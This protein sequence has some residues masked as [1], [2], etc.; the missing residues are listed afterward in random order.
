MYSNRVKNCISAI[1]IISLV[2]YPFFFKL[3]FSKSNYEFFDIIRMVPTYAWVYLFILCSFLSVLVLLTE[4][5]T[6]THVIIA[7][8]LV[9]GLYVISQYP[10]EIH[11]DFFVHGRMTLQV[12]LRGGI[13]VLDGYPRWWP[14][15]FIFWAFSSNVMGLG[16][17]ETGIILTFVIMVT[18]STLLYLLA[19]EI[20]GQQWAGLAT[21]LYL[22]TCVYAF[23]SMGRDHFSPGSIAFTQYLLFLYILIRIEKVQKFKRTF[24][25]IGSIMILCIVLSHGFTSLYLF[26]T[27]FGI[28]AIQKIRGT[29]LGSSLS[30][31]FFALTSWFA[32]WLFN[33]G[34][35]F[36]EAILFLTPFLV[37]P[38]E[39]KM[40]RIA[41]P[42]L[43]EPLPITGIILRN[44]YIK[45]LMLTI[46]FIS[47]LVAFK[48]RKVKIVSVYSGVLLGILA[49]SAIALA[50]PAETIVIQ[51]P[52]MLIFGLLPTC[53]LA[54]R[55]FTKNA[56][57]AKMSSCI[58]IFL[59]I[60]S[61]L[62]MF[63]YHS[64]YAYTTHS[65]EITSY[66]FIAS[67]VV[68][69]SVLGSD[70]ITHLAY[71]FF[72]IDYL[73]GM[74]SLDIT[75]INYTYRIENHPT[76]FKGDV[77]LRSFK[78]ELTYNVFYKTFD[79]RR[80]FWVKVDLNLINNQK[81]NRIYDNAYAQTYSS[82]K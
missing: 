35:T 8:L 69:S 79:E 44:Y 29:H 51:L 76:F 21:I 50:S 42:I 3:D 20:L 62:T 4:R 64:E 47:L 36:K 63:T 7:V 31:T 25:I 82:V 10:I 72:D 41:T 12:I 14:G 18:S 27:L 19:R 53:Y 67:N 11:L 45:P 55:F 15:A 43:E 70:S 1:L 71:R 56:L 57:R 24:Y 38:M 58:L 39:S 61:F 26:S 5:V 74:G 34:S 65:W 17:I 16:V 22:V 80:G 49:S 40:T 68:N 23:H 54:S 78:Q 52:R 2:I 9:Y 6:Y 66:Q 60:P 77:I 30:L 75:S 73:L 46:G 33:A 28:M 81:Y 37:S 59:I 13:Q 48:H 32:W